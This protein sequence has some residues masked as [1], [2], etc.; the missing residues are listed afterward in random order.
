M[1]GTS[2]RPH[3]KSRGSASPRAGPQLKSLP[4]GKGKLCGLRWVTESGGLPGLPWTP[5]FLWDEKKKV[6][7]CQAWGGILRPHQPLYLAA[8]GNQA[9]VLGPKTP[10][11]GGT[12]GSTPV[13]PSTVGMLQGLGP[14]RHQAT[15]RELLSV[16][17]GVAPCPPRRFIS[18]G[19]VGQFRPEQRGVDT[20]FIMTWDHR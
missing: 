6:A 14:L 9:R 19:R 16:R 3:R 11:P 20:A 8:L 1:E 10:T 2:P 12:P 4:C 17:L 13:R 15:P 5:H 7:V 18:L